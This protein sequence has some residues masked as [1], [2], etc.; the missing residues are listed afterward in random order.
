MNKKKKKRKTNSQEIGIR[1]VCMA[2]A[3][4]GENCAVNKAVK[5]YQFRARHIVVHKKAYND[6]I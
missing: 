4:P 2:T 1:L 6:I 5:Q 3:N